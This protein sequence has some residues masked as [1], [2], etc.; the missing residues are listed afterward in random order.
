LVSAAC[1]LV[2]TLPAAQALDQHK[3]VE[4]LPGLVP[5][6]GLGVE[7]LHEPLQRADGGFK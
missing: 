3:P 2:S 4:H 1:R 5:V 7:V 6:Q